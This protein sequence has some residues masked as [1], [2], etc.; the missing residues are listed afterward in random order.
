MTMAVMAVYLYSTLINPEI[1][2]MVLYENPDTKIK[3]TVYTCMLVVAMTYTGMIVLY[4]NCE[5]F[6]IFRTVM[7]ITVLGISLVAVLCFPTVFG[8]GKLGLTEILYVATTV[9]GGYFVVSILMRIMRSAK[10]LQ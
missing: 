6:D 9:L 3:I 8:V 2:N 4:K 7:M 5:P 10:L 1:S